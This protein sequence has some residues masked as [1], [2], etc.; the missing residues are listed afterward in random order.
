ML[1]QDR[2]EGANNLALMTMDEE[3]EGQKYKARPQQQQHR[4]HQQQ[5]QQSNNVGNVTMQEI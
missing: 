1:G 3:N 5:Q 4:C 2:V